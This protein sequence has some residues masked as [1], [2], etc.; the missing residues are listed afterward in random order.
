VIYL[1]IPIIDLTMGHEL[2]P[3]NVAMNTPNGLSKVLNDQAAMIEKLHLD[4][5]VERTLIAG[6]LAA[7]AARGLAAEI[8]FEGIAQVAL[9]AGSPEFGLSV[10]RR[11]ETIRQSI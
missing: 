11:I 6:I 2:Q 4:Y 9:T 3:G 1:A 7:L 10:L 8:N 5:A